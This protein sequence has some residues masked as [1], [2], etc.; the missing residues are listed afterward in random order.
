MPT[1]ARIGPYRFFFYGN[2]GKEPAHIHVQREQSLAKYWLNEVSLAKS[3]GFAAH[4]LRQIERL[5]VENKSK[6]LEAWNEFF[7]S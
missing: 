7:N 2:E 5:V 6:F 3:R 1:V 4:E